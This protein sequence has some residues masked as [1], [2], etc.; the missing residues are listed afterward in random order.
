MN[1][2][3][4]KNNI[5]VT[6]EEVRFEINKQIKSM[7]GQGKMVLEYY[8]KNPNA[9]QSLKGGIYEEKV[10][11]LMKSKVKLTIANLTTKEAEKIISDFNN[12]KS[13]EPK[14]KK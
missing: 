8:E 10:I 12:S 5:K 4:E 1:E 9:S 11:T 3:G 2:F 14:T 6:D 7:P 13:N